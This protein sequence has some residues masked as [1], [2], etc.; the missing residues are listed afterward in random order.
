MFSTYP[1]RTRF[2]DNSATDG[3]SFIVVS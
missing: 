1:N 3:F 2:V